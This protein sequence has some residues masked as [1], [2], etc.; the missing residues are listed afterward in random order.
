M[1]L[2]YMINYHYETLNLD[3]PFLKIKMGR[4]LC[5]TDPLGLPQNYA[6]PTVNEMKRYLFFWLAGLLSQLLNILLK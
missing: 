5:F 6:N 3:F 1:V 4:H 2:L